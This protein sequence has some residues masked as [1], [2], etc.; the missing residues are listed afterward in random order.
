MQ[1]KILSSLNTFIYLNKHCYIRTKN[2]LCWTCQSQVWCDLS[3]HW[4]KLHSNLHY[5][6]TM[7]SSVKHV[8]SPLSNI[9]VLLSSPAEQWSLRLQ[10][11][12]SYGDVHI[13]KR[14]DKLKKKVN[15]V[16]TFKT[17]PSWQ[18][19]CIVISPHFTQWKSCCSP[20]GLIWCLQATVPGSLHYTDA[21]VNV[22]Q[23]ALF[24]LMS[25]DLMSTFQKAVN[26][27][28]FVWGQGGKTVSFQLWFTCK[29]N[30]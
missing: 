30:N 25:T 29:R 2:K 20:W 5:T 8:F 3:P 6:A 7:W 16:C 9:T 27:S 18:E 23:D 1:N 12:K 24:N 21:G 11:G 13:W 17:V 22:W 14:K 15:S 19:D 26:G 10:S 28:D 4:G